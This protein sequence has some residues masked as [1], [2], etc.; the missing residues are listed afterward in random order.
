[1]F[2]SAHFM[3]LIFVV[4]F[5]AILIAA[6]E[7]GFLLG[8]KAESRSAENAKSQLGAVEGGILALLGLLLGF[9]MSMAVTRFEVRKQLVLDEAN[10]IQTSYLRTRLIPAPDSTEI[11]N[12]L[13]EY[14][15]VRLHYADVVDDFDQLQTTREQAERLQNEFWTRAVAYGQKDPNPVK[16]GLLLQ[17]LNQT[18]D[19][20]SARWMA[21]Q[22]HV[23]PT[24]I[25]VNF[26]VALLATILVG[27]AFGRQGQRQV[28][29]TTMLVLAITVVLAVIVDLDQP[30]QGFIKGSQQPLVDLQHL[31]TSKQ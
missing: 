1:M 11:A 21:F 9:T 13:R 14:V 4:F 31:L 19:L 18:I 2:A 30:R 22:N 25:Y 10:A 26:V 12:L 28:F 16:A 29:S 7:A 17:S 5:G 6:S 20:E 27:Y 23:P 8:R 24:V 3:W 15:A